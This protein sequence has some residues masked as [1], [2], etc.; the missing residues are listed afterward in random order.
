MGRE[1]ELQQRR[2]DE[3]QRLQEQLSREKLEQLERE[4]SRRERQKGQ[5][6]IQNLVENTLLSLEAI[7]YRVLV[8]PWVSLGSWVVDRRSDGSS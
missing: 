6:F 3:Y 8:Q 1:L 5:S 7:G 2:G 4:T